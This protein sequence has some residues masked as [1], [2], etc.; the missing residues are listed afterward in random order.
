MH[1]IPHIV[2]MLAVAACL[3]LSVKETWW[4]R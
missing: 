4:W 3:A 2:L 1:Y